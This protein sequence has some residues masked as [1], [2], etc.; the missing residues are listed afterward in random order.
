[1]EEFYTSARGESHRELNSRKQRIYMANGAQRIV[2][3]TMLPSGSRNSRGG[4]S[5]GL[6]AIRSVRI[7]R[8]PSAITQHCAII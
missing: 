4:S 5:L 3:G 7:A 6:R 2:A 1:M 8:D